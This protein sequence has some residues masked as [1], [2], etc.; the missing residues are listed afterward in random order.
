MSC[1]PAQYRSKLIQGSLI[2]FGG[3]YF[4]RVGVAQWPKATVSKTVIVGSNTTTLAILK[5]PDM[6][7]IEAQTELDAVNSMLASIGQAP[8]ST[9]AVTGIRDVNIAKMFLKSSLRRALTIGWDFNTDAD[10]QIAPNV[11]GLCLV[12]VGALS[13]DAKAN[14]DNIVQR[15]HPSGVMAFYNKD[16]QSFTFS[17][18]VTIKVIWGFSFEDIPEAARHYVA[19]YAGRRF[20]SK[21][22]GSQ[23]LDRYEEE[24]E[25]TAW[26]I[27]QREE[28]RSSDTNLFRKNASLSGFGN[29]TY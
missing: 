7:M 8:V 15:R 12:P 3:P 9:L 2:N 14:T 18:P 21:V 5:E 29:R 10:Y 17:E 25:M 20:Q 19:T 23:I 22:V 4:F 28:R 27:L 13:V 11:D 26:V 1:V 6:P 16:D 24:D